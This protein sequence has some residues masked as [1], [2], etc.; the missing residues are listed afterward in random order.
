MQSVA[1]SGARERVM[2][3]LGVFAIGLF[4]LLALPSFANAQ[5]PSCPGTWVSGGGGMMCL[6]PNGSYANGYPAVC[7]SGRAPST[8]SAPRPTARDLEAERKAEADRLARQQA[9]AEQARRKHDDDIQRAQNIRDAQ[10]KSRA[11]ELRLA[12][13]RDNALHPATAQ[14]PRQA[15]VSGSASLLGALK[16]PTALATSPQS[17]WATPTPPT[18]QQIQ[19]NNK[20]FNSLL[21]DPTQ[22]LASRRLAAAVLGKSLP[23]TPTAGLAANQQAS[24]VERELAAIAYGKQVPVTTSQP[25]PL[26][27]QLRTT[28]NNPNESVVN[29]KIAAI[30][31]GVDPNLIVSTPGTVAKPALA[32][33]ANGTTSNV[34]IGNT[35]AKSSSSVEPSPAGSKPALQLNSNLKTDIVALTPPP[36]VA[37]PKPAAPVQGAYSPPAST[38]APAP[39]NP[40]NVAV[41][42]SKT[43]A[44]VLPYA[45]MSRDAYSNT[46]GD[47]GT[48]TQWKRVANWDTILAQNGASPA[49]INAIRDSGFYAAVY[50]NQKTGAVSVAFRGTEI[51]LSLD[52]AKNIESA[53]DINADVG[54]AVG[55]LPLQYQAASTLT[56][57]VKGTIGLNHDITLTGHSL[58]GALASYAGNDNGIRNVVTFNSARNLVTD[59]AVNNPSQINIYSKGEMI[60]DP[61]Q[62]GVFGAGRLSGQN[63]GTD[64]LVAPAN[65]PQGKVDDLFAVHSIDNIIG[66]LTDKVLEK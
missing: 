18:P 33:T 66:S 17:A 40:Q 15:P 61:N 11:D 32:A 12:L 60:G 27:D 38:F 29:R 63:I 37:A 8:Y 3:A 57:V 5:F 23:D 54:A 26:D 16:N 4:T 7:P 43:A 64:S 19:A 46:G 9:L 10:V 22:P 2:K 48:A 42:D 55:G 39:A 24:Q 6:C 53:K 28:M 52:V 47:V 20:Y 36:T 34:V 30:A 13:Q 1:P 56:S 31:L 14:P 49:T 35:A 58:G 41:L 44:Q 59:G 45:L 50:Q 65:G 51:N 21:N 62:S 25:V